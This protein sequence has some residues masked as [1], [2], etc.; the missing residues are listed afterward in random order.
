MQLKAY[1]SLPKLAMP[2]QGFGV[3][4][5]NLIKLSIMK[6]AKS[7]TKKAKPK[8]AL[9]SLVIEP[10]VQVLTDS[11]EIRCYGCQKP[12]ADCT[13]PCIFPQKCFIRATDFN[14]TC[15]SARE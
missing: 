5:N 3:I 2:P 4:K 12:S 9:S 13:V 15:K 10:S 8:E 11:A 14:F 7:H 6:N 1:D